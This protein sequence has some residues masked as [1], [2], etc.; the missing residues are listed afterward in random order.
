MAKS[1]GNVLAGLFVAI[2]IIVLA[3][4]LKSGMKGFIQ[5]ERVVSVKG[6]A[7][8]E[9]QADRV[10]WPLIYK[11]IGD[12][13]SV[14]YTHMEKKN[15]T[16]IHFLKAHGIDASE[17][18]VSAPEIIDM[19]AERYG[20]N[21]VPYRY[22]VTSIL[23]VTSS[24]VDLVRKLMTSQS[25]LLKE[26]IAIS[27]GDYRYMTQFLFTK[28]N[29]IKP[30]MI[31][32]ATKNARA[33]AQKFA[34]DSESKLGKIRSASQGQFSINDRDANTPYIKNIRVVTTIDYYLND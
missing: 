1:Y 18:T 33:T 29:E 8:K 28:L 31:E 13:L 22:N 7:E 32:E 5:K 16:I 4:S 23:T 20:N 26:G 24:K 14:L 12:N 17:I 15:N 3:L 21:S 25:D 2:G 19:Q 10:I 9:V 30:G 11:E 34:E 6:L 27:G